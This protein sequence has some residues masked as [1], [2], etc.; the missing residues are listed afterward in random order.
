[1]GT[2][3]AKARPSGGT[4]ISSIDSSTFTHERIAMR[5]FPCARHTHR[6]VLHG[7][8][9]RPDQGLTLWHRQCIIIMRRRPAAGRLGRISREDGMDGFA[10]D[11][12][13]R[14]RFRLVVIALVISAIVILIAIIY[15][16]IRLA[17]APIMARFYYSRGYSWTTKGD[18]D[19]AIADN[20]WTSGLDSGLAEVF[21]RRSRLF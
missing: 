5:T 14:R 1:M 19:R 3:Q 18:Q 20:S 17:F 10:D 13:S 11:D 21:V 6:N 12:D 15:G 16:S 9:V 8:S 4:S 7:A 2:R